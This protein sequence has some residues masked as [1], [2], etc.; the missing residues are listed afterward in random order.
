MQKAMLARNNERMRGSVKNPGPVRVTQTL[1]NTHE[2]QTNKQT[3]TQTHMKNTA[4]ALNKHSNT[5]EK[6][7]TRVKQTLKHT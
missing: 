3:N 4:H 2:K 1:S 5:H 6:H 7:C